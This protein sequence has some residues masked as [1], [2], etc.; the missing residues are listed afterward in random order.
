MP[1][2][3]SFTP[4]AW[5]AGSWPNWA[6]FGSPADT[7][8]L[9]RPAA[10]ALIPTSRAIVPV[11]WLLVGDHQRVHHAADGVAFVVLALDVVTGVLA[12][13]HPQNSEDL[14]VRA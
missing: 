14:A 4:A 13:F 8:R 12:A 5:S 9:R 7:T 3:V 10:P 11:D 1:T 6:A 2:P